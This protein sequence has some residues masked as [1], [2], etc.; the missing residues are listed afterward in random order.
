MNPTSGTF[1]G[2]QLVAYA[3]R[4][5][6]NLHGLTELLTSQMGNAFSGIHIL[7]FFVP[8]DGSDA[9]FDPSDHCA[10]DPRLGNWEDIAGIARSHQVM[11]DV[12][13]N[14]IS[15]DSEQFQDWLV[16]GAE[17]SYAPMF[18]T[19]GRVF[20]DGATEADLLEIYRP[21]PGLC[22]TRMRLTDG[23]S[24]LVWT[25]FTPQ[26]I[27]IDVEHPVGWAY[28]T[29]IM[30]RLAEHGVT[31][32]RLDAVGYAIKRAGTS[33]FMIPETYEFVERLTEALHERGMTV[34]VEI[35][36]YHQMQIDIAAKVDLVYDF[37]LPPLVLDALYCGDARPLTH[38]LRIRPNNAI[39]VLDTH[40]GI[41][42][43][44]IGPDPRAP[45]RP[46][47]LPPHR[48]QQLVDQIHIESK[49]TSH[50]SINASSP[51]DLYQVNCTYFDAMGQDLERY[52]TARVIQCLVPGIPQIYYVG[53]LGGT[54]DLDLLSQT[55]VGRDVNRHHYSPAELAEALT[56]PVA[57]EMLA[58]FR[59]RNGHPV[60]AGHF[61]VLG[62][63]S[64]DADFDGDPEPVLHL[65]WTASQGPVSRLEAIINLA[66]A[67]WE[68]IEH[69]DD[70][71]RRYTRCSDLPADSITEVPARSAG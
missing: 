35:H 64:N 16:K 15:S 56:G 31:M 61:E 47:L 60:F 57:T 45:E 68:L 17:S 19:M 59:W 52:V 18:L 10:V 55:G 9:G 58:L 29:S 28:L 20:P 7:P 62:P 51:L 1:L 63:L 24:H 8:I 54:N 14:H 38:W 37:A 48:L 4:F 41:G 21:R 65:Q 22:F 69:R 33:S 32:V 11:A 50:L 44:D 34:L 67:R 30:D 53:L 43:I 25:T 12:I 36:G 27:D 49:G 70:D 39:T 40:D 23:S 2:T 46:G 3:D 26:Q 42:V 71:I 13:V 6:G 5:G 66:E